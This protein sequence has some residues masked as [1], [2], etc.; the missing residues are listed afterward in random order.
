MES[1]LEM[2]ADSPAKADRKPQARS[3]I[4]NGKD[5]LPSVDGR[6]HIARRYRD[7]SSQ[8]VTDQGGLEHCSESRL[9]LIRRFSAA[10]VLAEQMESRLA[11]GQAINI[12][13]H[14][15]LCSSLVRLASKIG[16][17]RIARDVTP[18]LG[19]LL[20]ADAAHQQ[21]EQGVANEQRRQ[22]FEQRQREQNGGPTT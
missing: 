17:E 2:P 8:I 22:E 12:A 14:A 4:S 5:V 19:S 16:I 11:R 3:R 7:I 20:A 9:Q 1:A 21:R 13:E 18:S 10:A 15:Q 6:S